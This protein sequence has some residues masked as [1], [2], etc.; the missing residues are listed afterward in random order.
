MERLKHLVQIDILLGAWLIVAPFILGYFRSRVEIGNDVG[1][2]VVLIACSLWIVAIETGGVG[3][4][5]L[6]LLAG[7]WLVAAPFFLH[8]EW[9]S[10]VFINDVIV[11]VFAAMVSAA[12]TWMLTSRLRQPA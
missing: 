4:S 3:A 1:T 2:G 12:A 8:Y 11:G 7:L 5:V 9:L 6:Q 10:R